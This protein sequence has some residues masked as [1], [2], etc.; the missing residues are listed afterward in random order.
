[1][2]SF[3]IVVP[4]LIASAVFACVPGPGMFYAAAQ[5]MSGGRRAGWYSALGFHIGGFFHI[6]AA[7]FGLAV[8]LKTIPVLYT[9]VKFAG[10]GYLIWLGVKYL[11]TPGCFDQ[12]SAGVEGK[13]ACRALRDSVVVEVL[14]PKSALFYLA[15]LPQFTDISAT[16][17]IWAQIMTLGAIVNV[18]FTVTDA[19]CIELS[20]AV[21]QRLRA[22]TATARAVRRMG[23]CILIGLG[24]KL[25]LSRQ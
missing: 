4:F 19:L 11:W 10:A 3:E 2:P 7:A 18:M 14:N 17:P 21:T 15:F 20:D 13:T 24:L 9:I 1:M 23:G 8:M 22:S 25:A 16:L 5:T 12:P 6:S